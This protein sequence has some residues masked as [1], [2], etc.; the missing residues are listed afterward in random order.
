MAFPP[1]SQCCRAVRRHLRPQYDSIWIPDSLL[2][3]AF[4]RYCAT[5]RTAA[6]YGSSLPGP[7]E[8]RRRLGKRHMGELNF[9]QTHPSAPLWQLENLVDL[10]QWQWKSPTSPDTR[11]RDR[12]KHAQKRTLGHRALDLFHGL[13]LH[14]PRSSADV[15]RRSQELDGTSVSQE[16]VSGGVVGA[17]QAVSLD[18]SREAPAKA[19]WVVNGFPL[20]FV[21]TGL[22]LLLA[23]LST[24]SSVETMPNVTRVCVSW[25]R[26]LAGGHVS[27][28]AICPTLKG[29]REGLDM[30]TSA[31]KPNLTIENL[32]MRL[33]EATIDGLSSR[34]RE[35]PTHFDNYAW[36]GILHELSQLRM[37]NI[38]VFAR[39][40]ECIPRK[41]LETQLPGISANLDTYLRGLERAT[42]DSSL[43]R[44]STKMAEVLKRTGVSDLP[45]LPDLLS[46]IGQQVLSYAGSDHLDYPRLRFGWLLL[47][48]KLPSRGKEH[49]AQ[50]CVTLEADPRY[51]LTK[52]EICRLF[53]AY[54]HTHTPL[55]KAA[56]LYNRLHDGD[57][58]IYRSL[59]IGFWGS[60]QSHHVRSF[61]EFLIH[62]GREHD[63][64][65][66]AKGVRNVVPTDLAL[67][68]NLA[69]GMGKPFLAIKF[70][71]IYGYSK[72]HTDPQG[73]WRS[74]YATRAITSLANTHAFDYEKLL[75]A[76]K[77]C[78]SPP[79][80]RRVRT[81]DSRGEAG[82]RGR[83]QPYIL[84]QEQI[85][86]TAK[87]AMI[88]AR[89][90]NLTNR[91]AFA[92]LSKCV[93]YLRGHNS[94]IHPVVLRSLLHN[95]TR[96]LAEGR[97]GKTA[98]LR[99]FLYLLRKE[100]GTDE[101]LRTGLALRRWRTFNFYLA[102]Q[103]HGHEGR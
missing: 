88:M 19:L 56:F 29:I 36:T 69:I 89:A 86:K 52:T 72:R 23:D 21:D 97:P 9:G 71:S 102:R 93:R 7:M 33:F 14:N 48:A 78:P 2:A 67:L 27:G 103:G 49:L 79:T 85:L 35:D 26:L 32:K 22:E 76:L 11:A 64:I 59:S 60:D 58:T 28:K 40:M 44:Q 81:G 100:A 4:E 91:N 8:N 77:I 37:N 65:E 80:R 66:L 46:A 68:A 18:R 96:D 61:A 95:I 54:I 47:V 90:P 6:R 24:S 5:S 63:I 57:A 17:Q 42:D 87:A 83:R 55:R 82:S 15:I 10:T 92:L 75:V 101:M 3:T 30:G 25:Q 70:F 53:L 94:V 98:R 34:E 41:H 38:R 45:D 84:R 73:F 20:D 12:E 1:T 62:L 50:V 51:R 43:V 16:P 99:W 39:A 31:A 74:S 13:L